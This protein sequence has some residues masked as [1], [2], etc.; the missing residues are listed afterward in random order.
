MDTVR[1]QVDSITQ[2]SRLDMLIA[3]RLEGHSRTSCK[4]L[5]TSNCVTING[6]PSAKPS[7][8]VKEGDLI[9]ITFPPAR[10]LELPQCSTQELGVQLLYEHDEF[11]IIYKPAG[12]I[13]HTPH[14]GSTEITLVDWLLHRFVE[15]TGVGTS[16]RPGIVHRLD[17]DTSGLMII[18]RTLQAH[19][20]FSDLF[21]NRKIEKVYQAFVTGRPAQEN[22]CDEP[23]GRHPVLRHKM[24][25]ISK[26]RSSS[27]HFKTEQYFKEYALISAFPK[28]GR[29]HQIRVHCAALG[30]PIIGDETYG[31]RSKKIARQALHAYQLSFEYKKKWFSF[32]YSMPEDMRILL[33]D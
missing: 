10:P 19:G 29:T 7:C 26:G 33:V 14:I 11:L 22:S 5:I 17:K 15:L 20:I 18:A 3:A 9:E 31:A 30:H 24:A 23:I 4:E 28:T 32:I 2:G 25:I 16:E 12:L 8:L 13:V 27:T 1:Y 21:Q 6:V